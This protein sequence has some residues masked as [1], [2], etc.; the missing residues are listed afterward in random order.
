MYVGLMQ[1][2]L[3]MEDTSWCSLRSMVERMSQCE[4]LTKIRCHSLAAMKQPL[5]RESNLSPNLCNQV[6][7]C[8][9]EG[10]IVHHEHMVPLPLSGSTYSMGLTSKQTGLLYLNRCS[11]VSVA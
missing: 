6:Q 2:G 10:Y 7:I 1:V 9:Q 5:E 11:C 4:S 8:A 3:L